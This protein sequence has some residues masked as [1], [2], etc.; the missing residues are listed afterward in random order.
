MRHHNGFTLKILYKKT[1]IVFLIIIEQLIS[2]ERIRK[3]LFSF[4]RFLHE[5]PISFTA[6]IP[7]AVKNV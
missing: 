6:D 4:Y 7:I 2:C 3:I 1:H 5:I